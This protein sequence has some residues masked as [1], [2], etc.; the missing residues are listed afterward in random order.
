VLPLLNWVT[1][2]HKHVERRG[3]MEVHTCLIPSAS[4][5]G[6]ATGKIK[7]VNGGL[8]QLSITHKLSKFY[9]KL[10]IKVVAK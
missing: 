8:R 2:T 4:Q 6:G 7:G 3:E 1:S 5:K 10:L 9:Y